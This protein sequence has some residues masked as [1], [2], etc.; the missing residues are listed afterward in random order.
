MSY[1]PPPPYKPLVGGIIY[2]LD[3]GQISAKLV[4]MWEPV[5]QKNHRTIWKNADLQGVIHPDYFPRLRIDMAC[6]GMLHKSWWSPSFLVLWSQHLLRQSSTPRVVSGDYQ[7]KKREVFAL[8]MVPF[9]PLHDDVWL[10][11]LG[12]LLKNL[13]SDVKEFCLSSLVK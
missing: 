10:F 11:P 13:R 6:Y 4:L 9:C 8:T 1:H 12:K 3:K 5:I 2:K 7:I